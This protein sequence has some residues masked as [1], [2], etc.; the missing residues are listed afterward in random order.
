[1]AASATVEAPVAHHFDNLRQ[2][3]ATIR[4]GMWVFLVTEVLFFA[5]V[6]VAYT[7]FRIWF[8]REFEAGSAVLNVGIATVNTFLLLTSSM[9][10]TLGIRACYVGDQ[11]GLRRW[12]LATMILGAGFFL[13]K[14]REYQLD[15]QEGL[16]PSSA[17]TRVVVPGSNPRAPEYR[18]VPEFVVHYRA[19]AEHVGYDVEGVNLVRVQL[20]FIF[21]YAMT[22]LHMLHM[23]IGIG[24]LVWQVVLTSR[25]FFAYPQRYIYVEVMSLYWHFVDMVWIFLFPL[26][27]LAGPHNWGQVIEGLRQ[28]FTFGGH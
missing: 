20:F 21:Y 13:L 14:L 23:T 4:F 27:Y 11:A 19:A 18:E 15:Y 5:G 2:Q 22:G 7:A 10:I 9:T 8:P 6:F 24:L 1:M 26:L 3:Q 17:T 25:G 28:A 12:L 16:V